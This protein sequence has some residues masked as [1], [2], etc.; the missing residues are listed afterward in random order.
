[1]ILDL[2][3][4]GWGVIPKRGMFIPGNTVVVL[5]KRKLSLSLAILG[6]L[7]P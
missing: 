3:D 7:M 2:T 4:L 1:M 5:M 6:L